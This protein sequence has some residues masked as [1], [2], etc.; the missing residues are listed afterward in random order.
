MHLF[1]NKDL[2]DIP[3]E[4]ADGEIEAIL[5]LRLDRISFLLE[6]L[7]P[8]DKAILLMKYKEGYDL[9]RIME[10]SQISGISATKM[11]LKRAKSRLIALYNKFLLEV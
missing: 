8:E 7:K 1:P 9:K 10:I 4:V 2:L 11:R 5:Q 3:E 6:L